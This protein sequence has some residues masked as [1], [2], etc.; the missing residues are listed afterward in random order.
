V[1]ECMWLGVRVG[2]EGCACECVAECVWQQD[3]G[4]LMAVV[5]V[6]SR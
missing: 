1:R 2:V 6:G 4:G 3:L 5:S